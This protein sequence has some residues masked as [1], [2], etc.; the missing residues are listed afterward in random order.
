M[1]ENLRRL[2]PY[3]LKQWTALIVILLLTLISAAASALQ[4][5]PMKL[6]VDYALGDAPL[7][8]SVGRWA[9]EWG[10]AESWILVIAAAVASLAVF[11]IN[12][13]L[14]VGLSLAWNIGGQRVVYSLA[15]DLY[16]HL[17][18]LS[19]LFHSRRS[20]GDSLSRLN[21]D[22]WCLYTVLDGLLIAPI[23]HFVTLVA[24]LG[25]AFWLDAQL[26]LIALTIAPL[27]AASSLA[28]GKPLKQRAR[29][30]RE[31]KSRLISFVHQTLGGIP[32]VQAFGTENRNARHFRLLADKVVA[33][34]QRGNLIGSTYGFVNG[35]VTTVGMAI[36]LYAG[37][38]RVLT[39]A[40]SLGTL[41]V[42]LSYA[43]KMQSASGGLF[44]VFTKLKTAEASVER[45]LDLM[46]SD[47]RV[48]EAPGA[49]SLPVDPGGVRGHIEFQEVTFGY[50]D[51]TPVLEHICL[52]AKPGEVLAL[53]GRTGAGKSTLV[54][55]IPRFFDPWQGCVLFDGL[56]IRQLTLASL[57][58]HISLVLQE[59]F[60]LPLSIADNIAYGCP[61]ATHS[62]IVEAARAAEADVFIRQLPQGYETVLGERGATLSG[63]ERQ[64]LAIARALLKNAPVLILDEPT[65]AVDAETEASLITVFRRLMQ[66]RT[67][68]I[69]AHRLSTIR[70]ADHIAVLENGRLAELGSHESLLAQEGL[71]SRF[72]EQQTGRYRQ[73]VA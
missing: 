44:Q 61:D 41:L 19:L 9:G 66:G 34:S 67:T 60:L 21:D 43:R 59:P 55:L 1:C 39:G 11:A 50:E 68:F 35:L 54:S 70:Q 38:V 56:D 63:G 27:L 5:W 42:F 18:R 16:M 4:P 32:I 71:Y 49:Q 62:Q 25:V 73:V 26:A 53:V 46:H 20:L 52:E 57:R 37:G 8:P 6:L 22:T 17:Q 24:L 45:V 2:F 13:L 23:Q 40:I 48:Y 64:R 58:S 69:I 65:A 51:G 36:L 30:G 14:G 47:E 7:P 28:F 3:L 29:Q 33:L 31:A 12:S 10:N 72:Y 15:G